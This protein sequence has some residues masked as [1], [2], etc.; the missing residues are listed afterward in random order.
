MKMPPLAVVIIA[1]SGCAWHP[2]HYFTWQQRMSIQADN[3]SRLLRNDCRSLNTATNRDFRKM[4][5]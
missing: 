4:G 1:L 2:V 3:A 5:D